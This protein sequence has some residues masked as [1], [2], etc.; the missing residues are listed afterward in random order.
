MEMD[1]AT[2]EQS[3][4]PAEVQQPVAQDGPARLLNVLHLTFDS[5]HFLWNVS[6]QQF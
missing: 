1:F 6:I 5:V 3:K 2:A 4:W